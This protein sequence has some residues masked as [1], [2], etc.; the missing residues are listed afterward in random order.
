MKCM[1]RITNMSCELNMILDKVKGS[2]ICVYNGESK[3]FS[4]KDEFV[5]SNI[6]K[7]CCISSISVQDGMIVLELKKVNVPIVDANS[8][9]VKEYEKQF[10]STPSFF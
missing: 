5:G 3:V 4:S 10:G 8:E 9:W 2:F 1:K 6:E 7:N